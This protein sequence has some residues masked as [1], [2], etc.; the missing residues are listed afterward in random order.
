MI[1]ENPQN[2][3]TFFKILTEN[4]FDIIS[5]FSIDGTIVFESEATQRILGYESGER[6]GLNVFDFVHPD[7]RAGIVRIF[8]RAIKKD[9]KFKTVEFRYQHEDGNWIW[10]EANGKNLIDNPKVRGILINS[11]DITHKKISEIEL[12]KRNFEINKLL[13]CTNLLLKTNDFGVTAKQIFDISKDVTGAK[14]G[15]VTLLNKNETENDIIFI[16]DGGIENTVNTYMPRPIRGLREIVYKSGKTTYDNDYLKSEHAKFLPPGHIQLKNVLL[17]PLKFEGKVIG[18]L[19]LGEKENGFNENDAKLASSFAE[20]LSIALQNSRYFE[21]NKQDQLTLLSVIDHSTNIFYQ[22]DTNHKL[23]YLSPQVKDILGYE[24]E[25]ALKVWTELATDNEINKKGL[26]NTKK[27]I[28]TGERQPPYMLELKHKSGK[29]IYVEV[30]EAPILENGKTI[31]ITGTLTDITEQVNKERIIKDR[32]EQYSRFFENN[33]NAIF[34]ANTAGVI[35][36]VNRAA[37][38]M[39]ECEPE[40]LV[41]MHQS[42]LHP[43]YEK[44]NAKKSFI[45]NINTKSFS[46]SHDIITKKK[47]I[48][49]VVIHGTSISYRNKIIHQG[50]F[51][52]ITKQKQAELAL[53]ESEKRIKQVIEKMPVAIVVSEGVEEKVTYMNSKF[54]EVFGYSY[55]EIKTVQDWWNLAYPDKEYREKISKKWRRKIERAIETKNE[56]EPQNA[57]VISKNGKKK[58]VKGY[59]YSVGDF[60]IVTLIDLT[61]FKKTEQKLIDANNTKDKFFSIISHDLKS[62]FNSILG[63]SDLLQENAYEYERDKIHK[64]AS[65]INVSANKTFNLLEN[66][67]EW[68]RTQTGKIK[69]KPYRI[70]VEKIILNNIRQF[71]LPAE[72][73]NIEIKYKVTD[74][75]EIIADENMLDTILRNLISNSIKFT[76][77]GG[78]ILIT[79]TQNSEET[80]FS[81]EDNGV[82]ITN[83]A[84]KKLF[85]IEEKTS[86]EGTNKEVGTGLG[87]LL[88]KEFVEMHGGRIW[89]ESEVGKGSE[90]KFVLPN[91]S[92][93]R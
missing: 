23:T 29:N 12:E 62:P 70:I 60:N 40:E 7:D 93:N 45:D 5:V 69:F 86:T 25:E 90:F 56:I 57:Y 58:F 79:V 30:R 6:N 4:S 27:A 50:I 49:N 47:N 74:A 61:D 11:R 76:Q 66:L 68:S 78:K 28:E 17:A 32:E 64:F 33:I 92:Y 71:H 20:L 65:T 26:E 22:H 48:K 41:G 42:K 21:N 82:G 84:L 46:V 15:Y 18:L 54:S 8:S 91:I 75:L 36:R 37:G 59:A 81:V 44:E 83:E 77:E 80:Y 14:V 67:L 43:D 39:F 85:K 19:G 3:P 72:D 63:F 51:I 34:W 53:K 55:E 89:V 13:E 2:S 87:L 10:L 35:E 1:I 9:E 24:S 73:K 88:C 31:A 52:D 38:K 16:E